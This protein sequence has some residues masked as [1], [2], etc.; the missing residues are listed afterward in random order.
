MIHI[1]D[2]EFYP[3]ILQFNNHKINLPFE[4]IRIEHTI[5]K[6][7][8]IMEKYYK[9]KIKYRYTHIFILG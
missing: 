4:N 3:K 1:S 7:L 8:L 5:H 9:A 2:K 6:S